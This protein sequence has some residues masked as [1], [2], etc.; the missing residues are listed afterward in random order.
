MAYCENCGKAYGDVS[1]RFCLFDGNPLVQETTEKT[2]VMANE[3]DQ[4]WRSAE[5]AESEQRLL[6]KALYETH[7]LGFL[8]H[9]ARFDRLLSRYRKQDYFFCTR[10]VWRLVGRSE[11][12]SARSQENPDV[13]TIYR[14]LSLD[15]EDEV[16]ELLRGDGL[17]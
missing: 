8:E 12:A 17:I 6:I 7:D 9:D 15:T 11:R 2:L 14:A 16:D 1:Y 4:S 3:P 13:S 5:D 10:F